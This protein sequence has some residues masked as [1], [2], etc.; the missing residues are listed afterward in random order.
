MA[1]E[2]PIL[3]L[4]MKFFVNSFQT[5][6]AALLLPWHKQIISQTG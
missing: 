2:L 3:S 1:M 6:F 5:N 4:E